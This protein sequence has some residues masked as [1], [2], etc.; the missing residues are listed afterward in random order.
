MANFDY[1]IIGGGPAGYTVAML[2][3]KQGASVVLFEKD[4][5]GGTCLNRGCIPTKSLLHNSE[6][7]ANSI[8]NLLELGIDIDKNEIDINK[9]FAKKDFAV[10]KIRKSLELAVKNSGVKIVYAQANILNKQEIEAKEEIYSVN[11]IIL[12]TGSKPRKLKG[13]EYDGDFIINSDDLLKMDKLPKSILIV[14]SGAIGI[15]WARIFNN[16]DVEVILVEMAEHL[17]PLADVD[18]SKR[19]ERIFKQQK[20]SY[21]LKDFIEVINDKKVLLHSGKEFEV[22]KVLIA[23][24]REPL[25]KNIEGIDIL[26]DICGEIQLAH[27]AIS[28]AKEYALNLKLKK[29]LVP[30]VVYGE[31]EI[32]WVGLREQDCDDSYTKIQMPITALGKSWCDECTDGFIK[33][34][35]KDNLIY[36]AHIVSKEA[37]SMIHTVLLA[38]QNQ[39]TINDLQKT[40]FAHPTYSEGIADLLSKC[41]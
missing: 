36:G 2:L 33:F 25:E 17:L 9:I 27:Y 4:Q 8:K 26:G 7:Y 35:I 19:V 18:V 6:M 38:I 39:I 32:A 41:D 13:F 1:G 29:N 12:A 34:I 31:P 16:F 3:A 23:I 14:G 15:E 40:C 11:K 28:Q 21:F 30:S 22:E 37:S 20:I 24:G 5:L 10:E